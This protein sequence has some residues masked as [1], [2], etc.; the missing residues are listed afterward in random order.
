MSRFYA[1]KG[2]LLA[3]L[4]LG[5]GNLHTAFADHD[6][7]KNNYKHEKNDRKGTEN[8]G[9]RDLA[10]V[11]NP[12]YMENC[13]ACHFP[14]QPGLLPLG[15]W[16]RI[17]S[18]LTDHFGQTVEL[19]PDSMKTIAEYL[20]THAADRSSAKLSRKIMKSLRDQTPLRITEITYI[21]REHHEIDAGVFARESIGSFSNCIACHKTAENGVY[22][23]DFVNIP[24]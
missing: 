24:R 1:L 17:L 22:D 11:N 2:L 20:K 8:K 4:L 16:G 3:A 18:G 13:S 6:E 21:Q 12:T 5:S 10:A 23:D 9:H 7:H 19:D 15:S 14:Y